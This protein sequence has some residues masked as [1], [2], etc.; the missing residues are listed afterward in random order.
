[1]LLT[2]AADSA[3]GANRGTGGAGAGGDGDADA[4]GR[5]AS[6]KAEAD[7]RCSVCSYI[8]RCPVKEPLSQAEFELAVKVHGVPG[9]VR[10]GA[11]RC[12][13]VP[14][15]VPLAALGTRSIDDGSH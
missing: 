1:M 8:G 9:G 7:N 4:L 10:C 2:F 6:G 14:T 13:A 5:L 3:G 15:Y 11:V 12:G